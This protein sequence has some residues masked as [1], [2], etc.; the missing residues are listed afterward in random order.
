MAKLHI[1]YNSLFIRK[2]EHAGD[3][4]G[5]PTKGNGISTSTFDISHAFA[6]ALVQGRTSALT[7]SS[8]DKLY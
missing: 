6:P 1:C 2:D 7:I 4:P 3:A 5:A 8:T